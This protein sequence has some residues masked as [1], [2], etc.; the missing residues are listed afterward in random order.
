MG[1]QETKTYLLKPFKTSAKLESSS[2]I[3]TSKEILD[4]PAPEVV[5]EGRSF[6]FTG[7]FVFS[8]G[9]REQC[10]AAVRT[11]GGYCYERPNRDLNYLVIGTFAEPAWAY[12]TYGRK[13]ETTLELKNTGATC[14]I[15]SEKLW[16]SSVKEIPQLPK[17]QQTT[18]EHQTRNHQIIH[19]QQ[20]L[21]RMQDNQRI[22]MDILKLEIDPAIFR[23]LNE[24]LCELGIK[25]QNEKVSVAAKAAGAFAGRTFVLT[26]T[27]PTMSREEATAKIEAAGGKVSGSVSKKTDFVLAG[28]EAGSKLEKARQLGVKILDEPEFLKLCGKA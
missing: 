2:Q 6:C 1:V 4:D 12:K 19:L 26:G 13:I 7:V 8:D 20:E 14:K 3:R 23:K 9:D 28:A 16:T 22:L 21:Q 27:L 18:F 5:F 10:E 25:P 11:R 15:I 24:R 17:D